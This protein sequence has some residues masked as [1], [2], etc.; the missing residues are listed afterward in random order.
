[1]IIINDTLLKVKI[2]FENSANTYTHFLHNEST[3]T[4]IYFKLETQC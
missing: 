2:M 4:L 1:M 3:F